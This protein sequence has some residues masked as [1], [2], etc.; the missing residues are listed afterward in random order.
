MSGVVTDE[1]PYLAKNVDVR[2]ATIRR[3]LR[4]H[5]ALAIHDAHGRETKL[6]SATK[7]F[8]MLIEK[9]VEEILSNKSY[10][11]FNKNIKLRKD[12]LSGY[13]ITE[14]RDIDFL[15]GLFSKY[16][17]TEHDGSTSVISQLPSKNDIQQDIT[18]YLAWK[19]DFKNRLT[20][21][22]QSY[23]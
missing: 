6:D 19:L 9:T 11:R 12:F 22:Q 15:L 2:I 8:R 14:E 18:G 17:V 10:Q 7:K 1:I 23:N 13:I 16:S 20:A 3:I 5:D 4:E 21:F